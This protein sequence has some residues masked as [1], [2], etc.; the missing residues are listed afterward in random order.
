MILALLTAWAGRYASEQNHPEY[1]WHTLRT[2]H[3]DIHYPRSRRRDPGDERYVDGA[4]MAQQLAAIA[5]DTWL[6]VC[7][8]VAFYPNERL[9]VV[10]LEDTDRLVGFTLTQQGWIVLSGN[11]GPELARMRGRVRWAPDLLAHELAHVITLKKAGWFEEKTSSFGMEIGGLAETDTHQLGGSI[12]LAQDEPFWWSEGVAEYA[13]ELAGVNTWTTSRRM[14]LHAMALDDRLLDAT[15]WHES[16]LLDDWYGAERAYQQ[17]YGF[18]RWFAERYGREA[19][20][21]VMDRSAKRWQLVWDD[22]YEA[23]VGIPLD[24]LK[25]AWESELRS[26]ALTWQLEREVEGVVE[27]E[28][29]AMWSLGWFPDDLRTADRWDVT[30]R[31]EQDERRLGTGTMTMHSHFSSDGR[32]YGRHRSGWLEVRRVDEDLF[33]VFADGVPDWD[34]TDHQRDEASRLS[35]WLPARY[36]SDFDFVPGAD[37][38][39][40]VGMEDAHR[41][42]IAP[43]QTEWT[44]LYRVDLTPIE[45][46]GL[47]RLPD[48]MRRRLTPIPGTLRGSDPS[49]SPDG[50]RLAWARYGDGSQNLVVSALDGSTHRALT[51]FRDGSYLQGTDWS[52]DGERIVAAIHHG[53][54]QDLWVFDVESGEGE[55]LHTDPW[56]ALDPHWADDGSIWFSA[57]VDGAFDIFR[58]DPD[59]RI[60]RMTRVTTGAASPVV[61]PDGDLVY[62]H[63]TAWGWKTFGIRTSELLWEDATSR[64]GE[65]APPKPAP[66]AALPTRPYRAHRALTSLALSPSFRLDR[67]ADGLVLPR[68]GAYAKLRDAAELHTFSATAWIGADAFASGRWTLHR[69]WPD[70]T[71]FGSHWAGIRGGRRQITTGGLRLHLPWRQDLWAELA[72]Y[73][74][75]VRRQ[76]DRYRATHQSSVVELSIGA[77]DATALARSDL[78]TGG[79]ADLVLTRGDSK[80]DRRYAY[81][82]VEGRG[83]WVTDGPWENHRWVFEGAFGVTDRP[84]AF[85]DRLAVGGDHAYALRPG[86][87]QGTLAFPGYP[88]FAFTAQHLGKIGL[89]W[90]VPLGVDLRESMGPWTLHTLMLQFGGDGGFVIEDGSSQ[91]LLDGRIDL[92]IGSTLLGSRFDTLLRVAAARP[93]GGIP[94]GPRVI[95]AVGSGF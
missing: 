85:D 83:T 33:T 13:S 24:E 1:A 91:W 65:P 15:D 37:A 77:G 50:T 48:T 60:D 30:P 75:V 68:L 73:G 39:V 9:H 58:R 57:D 20:L 88:P 56:E 84:V 69:F 28:E 62:H 61:T 82:R 19:W 93:T 27:G 12:P 87:V 46:D 31:E 3:F 14:T 22:V 70:V 36:L 11:P 54:T 59:G 38:L 76:T 71:V 34:L 25:A 80:A 94:S 89:G 29:L 79:T 10:V 16:K 17:G 8:A 95:L 92:R 21:E 86:R 41:T 18:H 26:E 35:A 2:E 66:V 43:Q 55:P 67:T 90:R 53:D 32:W 40:M 47:P 81:H 51:T 5:D 49:V 72:W 7:R 64:F 74:F 63:F 42:A 45:Q 4:S 6:E 52:P 78:E 44:R 23:V